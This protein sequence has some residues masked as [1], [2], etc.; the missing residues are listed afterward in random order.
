MVTTF[1]SSEIRSYLPG[2]GHSAVLSPDVYS[3]SNRSQSHK[4]SHQELF[5]E[6]CKHTLYEKHKMKQRNTNQVSPK[7]WFSLGIAVGTESP[8]ERPTQTYIYN[9]TG[10]QHSGHRSLLYRRRS[11]LPPRAICTD[12]DQQ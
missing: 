1:S 8:G 4:D 5:P 2:T 6:D 11:A 7:L 9:R 10:P 12:T 3:S